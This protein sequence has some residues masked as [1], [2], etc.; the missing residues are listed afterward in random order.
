MLEIYDEKKSQWLEL[1]TEEE[2]TEKQELVYKKMQFTFLSLSYQKEVESIYN[3]IIT[4]MRTL[5]FLF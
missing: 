1:M 5:F 2:K 4:F 3:R